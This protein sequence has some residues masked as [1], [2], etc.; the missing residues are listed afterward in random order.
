MGKGIYFMFKN[1]NKGQY[2]LRPWAANLIMGFLEF[3][4]MVGW[5]VVSVYVMF[6]KLFSIL[7]GSDI[8]ETVED[9]FGDFLPMTGLVL[10]GLMLIWNILV[11]AIKPLRT[12]MNYKESLWNIVFIVWNVYDSIHMMIDMNS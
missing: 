5:L 4:F 3:V 7:E 12:K 8:M 9:V 1:Y 11:W 10:A 6:T 2:K